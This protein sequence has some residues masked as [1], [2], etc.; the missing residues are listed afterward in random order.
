MLLVPIL[1]LG[2]SGRRCPDFLSVGRTLAG[3]EVDSRG[4]L[5]VPPPYF[6]S[7]RKPLAWPFSERGTQ[8][9]MWFY[10]QELDPSGGDMVAPARRACPAAPSRFYT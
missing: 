2:L 5:R 10:N 6:D 1:A 4:F 8:S 9:R 7:K 3:L